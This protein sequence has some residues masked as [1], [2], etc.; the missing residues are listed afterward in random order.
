MMMLRLGLWHLLHSLLSSHLLVPRLGRLHELLGR[1]GHLHPT[2]VTSNS[3]SNA[4]IHPP[5]SAIPVQIHV[6][7]PSPLLLLLLGLQ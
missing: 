5:S 7:H 4:H 2:T 1:N 3:I 6:I